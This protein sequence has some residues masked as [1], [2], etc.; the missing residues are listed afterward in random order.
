MSNIIGPLGILEHF[1]NFITFVSISN[2]QEFEKVLEQ[3]GLGFDQEDKDSLWNKA[4][5]DKLE[6]DFFNNF[7]L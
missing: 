6:F 4:L 7:H 3:H 1:S 2:I 5:D